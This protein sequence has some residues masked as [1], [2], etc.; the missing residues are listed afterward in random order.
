MTTAAQD[1]PD[2]AT[3]QL[4]GRIASL[5]GSNV[6]SDTGSNSARRGSLCYLFPLP[7]VQRLTNA[8]CASII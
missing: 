2:L 3:E 8:V 1:E 5:P 7:P 6:I 4:C